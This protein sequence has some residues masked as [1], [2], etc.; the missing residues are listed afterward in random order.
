MAYFGGQRLDR[1]N[2][3]STA[4]VAKQVVV[5]ASQCLNNSIELFNVKLKNALPGSCPSAP[6]WFALEITIS[7][8]DR[9]RPACRSAHLKCD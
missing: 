9:H 3:V 6:F 2:L 5:D 4:G 8:Q 1:G 7:G